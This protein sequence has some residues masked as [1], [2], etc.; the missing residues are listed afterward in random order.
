MFLSTFP[1][2]GTRRGPDPSK[3]CHCRPNAIFVLHVGT[4]D[5]CHVLM[6][7]DGFASP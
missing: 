3:R 7:L 2:L 6:V 4:R 5:E 1:R